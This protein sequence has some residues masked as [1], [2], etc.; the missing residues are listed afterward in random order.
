MLYL[1]ATPIGN[2]KELTYRAE[3]IL[4]S[5]DYIACEDTRTSKTLLDNYNIVK[6]LVSYYKFNEIAS[7]NKLIED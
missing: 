3:E 6:P 4:N 7:G 5:V 1:V 2:L